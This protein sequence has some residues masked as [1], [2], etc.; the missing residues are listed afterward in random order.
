[1]NAEV[2][3]I[4]QTP[5]VR[6]KLEDSGFEVRPGTPDALAALQAEDTRRL[7]DI[8]RAAAIRAE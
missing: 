7:G 6:Q 2:V 5:A 3:R 1:L 8:I 4:L